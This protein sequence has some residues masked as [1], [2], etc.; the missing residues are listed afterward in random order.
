[1]DELMAQLKA[2]DWGGDRG[3]LV[4]IDDRI[5]GAQ[6][7][8]DKLAEIELALLDVL[9]SDAK[10]PAKEYICRKLTLIGTAQCVPALAGMLLDAELSDRARIALEAI[11][12]ASVDDALRAA[13]EKAEGNPRVGI[14]NTLGERRDKKAIPGLSEMRNSPDS[15]LS[16][17]AEAA[18]RKIGPMENGNVEN[19]N[20]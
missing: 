14:V 6:G 5:V 9:Q 8:K 3:A 19:A 12:D 17:A 13:L 16:K 20:Q 11:P 1:M 10:L 4:G 18:L 2:Y 15:V 7:A